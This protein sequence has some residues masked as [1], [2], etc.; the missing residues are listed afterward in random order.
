MFALFRYK[1]S[2]KN[3]PPAFSST[4][5]TGGSQCRRRAVFSPTRKTY[6]QPK[7]K[8]RKAIKRLIVLRRAG[9]KHSLCYRSRAGVCLSTPAQLA[10]SWMPLLPFCTRSS[11]LGVWVPQLWLQKHCPPKGL[12]LKPSAKEKVGV[13]PGELSNDQTLQHGNYNTE[14]DNAALLLMAFSRCFHLLHTSP[15]MENVG[16][17][18]RSH[19]SPTAAHH[20]WAT[21]DGCQVSTLPS[22]VTTLSSKCRLLS[23]KK[24][25]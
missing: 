6:G 18:P 25:K 13:L 21:C 2:H 11:G 1:G 7:K 22:E 5:E 4:Q 3:P 17:A 9:H 12:T 19:R 15:Q 24:M 20:K 8:S 23:H 10:V 14:D 16:R